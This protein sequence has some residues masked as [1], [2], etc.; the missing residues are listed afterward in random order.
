M[1][2]LR[3]ENVSLC[4]N[5]VTILDQVSC[6]ISLGEHAVILGPNGSG[7][8]SLVKLI[9]RFFYPSIVAEYQGSVEIFGQTEWN[10]W[11]LRQ[12]LGYINSEI[13]F[14]FSHGRSG[15][16]T[17]L[18]A[19]LTGFSSSELEIDELLLTDTM[20]EQAFEALVRRGIDHL[21]NRP[22]A[23]LST[24]ERRKV[25]LARA[26]VHAPK[27]LLLDEPTTGLDMVA[28]DDL[29]DELRSI[30]QHGT[31][32]LL[33]THHVEEIVP[34]FR[35]VILLKSGKVAYQGS[36]S[37]CLTDERLSEVFGTSIKVD[38]D[39]EGLLSARLQRT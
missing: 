21:M 15:R 23:Y 18:Q 31:T 39:S 25:L 7:K 37:Q 13:D 14:H 17:A 20:R 34:E 5:R 1:E 12:Q 29:L 2:L 24:G 38:V 11:E 33:V 28:R 35:Q 6:S 4:R 8:T 26:L 16:L 27:A 32:L 30:A 22:V 36:R 9:M 3:L 19:V 10:V